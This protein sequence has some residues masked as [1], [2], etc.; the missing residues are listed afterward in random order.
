MRRKR[1]NAS[2]RLIANVLDL[3]KRRFLRRAGSTG[4]MAYVCSG[5]F[6]FSNWL[7]GNV[8]RADELGVLDNRGAKA[9]LTM[10]RHLYP[11]DHL[12]DEYYWAVVKGIDKEMTN[13]PELSARITSGF[14]EMGSEAGIEF[15]EL[16]ADA[17]IAAM[18]RL[19]S[20]P[21]FTDMLEKTTLYFYNNPEVWPHFGY[22]GSSWEKGGYIDRGFD[23]AD[24]IPDS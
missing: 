2:L 13:D 19:E 15:L 5:S 18:Q 24:W 8:A 23:D 10:A 11:H 3:S 16:D 9:M 7:S 6:A 21:F 20:T 22:Q 14:E 12:G 4:L 17:Q 1:H